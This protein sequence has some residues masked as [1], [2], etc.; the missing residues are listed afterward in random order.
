[1]KNKREFCVEDL[2]ALLALERPSLPPLGMGR[3]KRRWD[4]IV[5]AGHP[6]K[7]QLNKTW[8]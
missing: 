7:A 4:P 6:C 5:H 8:R 3:S 2:G 1:M